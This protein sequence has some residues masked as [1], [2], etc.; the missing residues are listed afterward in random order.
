MAYKI[1]ASQCTV[2]GACE[3]ECPNVAISLKNDVYV[4]DPKKCTQCEEHCDTPQCAVICPVPGTCVQ[5]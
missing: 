3:F 4:I 5:A 1:I 2:C